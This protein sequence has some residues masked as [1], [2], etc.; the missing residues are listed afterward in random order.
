M[1]FKWFDSYVVFVLSQLGIASTSS[2]EDDSQFPD[3]TYEFTDATIWTDYEQML[4]HFR[5]IAAGHNIVLTI[6]RSILP[7]P[8]RRGYVL[9]ACEQYGHYR[10]RKNQPEDQGPRTQ[11]KLRG[12]RFALVGREI[13]RGQWVTVVQHGRHNHASRTC[14]RRKD[15]RRPGRVG[16]D[17][18]IDQIATESG[19]AGT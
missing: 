16:G 8:G 15:R 14:I 13:A 5:D 19:V 2:S 3:Y 1:C 7:T 11:T 17:D 18:D 9:L 10:P 6:K 4:A 12:C